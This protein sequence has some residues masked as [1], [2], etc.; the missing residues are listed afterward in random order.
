MDKRRW[1]YGTRNHKWVLVGSSDRDFGC[2]ITQDEMKQIGKR[3]AL[4]K[5]L[6]A[7]IIK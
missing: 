3:K 1:V 7:C 6:G 5:Y 2:A 4:K